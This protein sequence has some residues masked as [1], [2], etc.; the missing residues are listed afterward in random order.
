MSNQITVETE[1]QPATGLDHRYYCFN[2]P[3]FLQVD[4]NTI[5]VF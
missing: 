4:I 3:C 1:V 5:I 2:K